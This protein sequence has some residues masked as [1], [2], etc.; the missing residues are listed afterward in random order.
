[1]SSA[2][3]LSEYYSQIDGESSLYTDHAD[4]YTDEYYDCG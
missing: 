4:C 3:L 2:E 1:M